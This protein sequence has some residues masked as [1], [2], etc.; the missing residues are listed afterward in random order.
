MQGRGRAK[1]ILLTGFDAFGGERVNPSWQVAER[2][3]GR[4]FADA[5]VRAVRLPVDCRR[6]AATIVRIIERTAPIAVVSLGQAAGRFGLSLER[7]ALNLA[8]YRPVPDVEAGLRSVPVVPNGPAAYFSRLPLQAI[9]EALRNRGIPAAVSLSAG[10]YVCNAV[11]YAELHALRRRTR[12]PVGFVHLP[13]E[14]AQTV[15]RAA[16]SMALD[17]MIAG[18]ET[19]LEVVAGSPGCASPSQR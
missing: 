6:A 10:V 18:V 5:T 17:L 8:D 12:I 2:L 14:A 11:M 1:T 4:S 15:R 19:V 7:V 16:A 9:L 13:Y 3:D